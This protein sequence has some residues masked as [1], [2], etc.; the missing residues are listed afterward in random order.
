MPHYLQQIRAQNMT[1]VKQTI[2]Q[3]GEKGALDRQ[4]KAVLQVRFGFTGKAIH[5]YLTAL[6]E[7]GEII[8]E[9]GVWKLG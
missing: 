6:S 3:T 8:N 1:L 5:N 9:K 7:A 2:A 4:L